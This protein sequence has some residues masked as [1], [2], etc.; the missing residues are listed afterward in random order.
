MTALCI[1]SKKLLVVHKK[2]ENIWLSLGGKREPG[3]T[4]IETLTR[5]V[6]E[7]INCKVKNPQFFGVF[8]GLAFDGVRKM[9]ITCYLVELEGEISLNPNDPI[10]Q[11]M[12]VDKD[13]EKQGIVLAGMLHTKI[14][15][16]L[17][18]KGLL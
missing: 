9:R 17:V 13:Y 4:D 2:T 11:V 16:E 15:P 12:W 8:E 1:K 5:E 3:E 18:K 6:K 7:E 14:V 10:D